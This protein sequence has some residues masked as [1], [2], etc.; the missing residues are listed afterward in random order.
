MCKKNKF[1]LRIITVLAAVV[2]VCCMTALTAYADDGGENVAPD[3]GELVDGGGQGADSGADSGDGGNAD[4][5]PAETPQDG[6]SS[7]AVDPNAGADPNA[8]ENVQDNEENGN[9][10]GDGQDSGNQNE[11]PAVTPQVIADQY[12]QIRDRYLN[13]DE[14]LPEDISQ[15]VPNENLINLPT[16]APTEVVAASAEPL[17]D[18]NVSDATL[19][20][21][22]IM[23][24][25]V[26]VGIS[27]VAGVMVSKRTH[28]RSA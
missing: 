10:S 13:G 8:G 7:S 25:C 9:N 15:Y 6:G 27:V 18:V 12:E 28:R 11:A 16:V 21:G 17:P 22:I 2:F 14:D 19:F 5:A 4:P 24:V 3:G 1:F 26:A 23:W 20:S